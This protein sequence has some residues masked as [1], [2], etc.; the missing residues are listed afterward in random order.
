M[1]N[2]IRKITTQGHVVKGALAAYVGPK[3]AADRA[4]KPGELDMVLK[5]IPPKSYSQQIPLI[6]DA[7]KERFGPRLARDLNIDDL[8][9]ILEALKNSDDFSEDE[10][11]DADVDTPE[12]KKKEEALPIKDED[13]EDTAEDE[14]DDA[15]SADEDDAGTK[16]MALLGKYEIST[17]DLD[18]INELINALGQGNGGEMKAAADE[19]PDEK[20]K[21]DKPEVVTKAAMD[22]ALALRENR[23]REQLRELFTAANDVAPLIGQVDTLAF[24]SADAIYRLALDHAGVN[25]KGIHPSAYKAM[26]ELAMKRPQAAPTVAADAASYEDFNKRFPN[27]PAQV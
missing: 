10:N 2:K 19:F 17:E 5:S 18:Q 16:L 24:D 7:I 3:L 22:R 20:K 21:D 25:T 12:V 23:Q 9:D 6:A 4:I 1:A 11:P 14:D 27:I 26:L 13:K 15:V 8:P